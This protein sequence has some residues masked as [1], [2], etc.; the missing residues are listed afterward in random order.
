MRYILSIAFILFAFQMFGQVIPRIDAFKMDGHIINGISDDTTSAE[1]DSLMTQRA[2]KELFAAV[3]LMSVL[4]E[5]VN[6]NSNTT[7]STNYGVVY[8][9]ASGGDITLTLPAAA[10]SE[11]WR[12]YIRRE[13]ATTNNFITITDGTFTKVIIGQYNTIHIRSN[14]INWKLLF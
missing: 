9:D 12:Y 6:I 13:D 1:I 3:S 7:L 4:E 14:G 10:S 5:Y 11:K 8:A 2:I